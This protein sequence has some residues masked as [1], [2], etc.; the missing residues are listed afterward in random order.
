MNKKLI[1][2]LSSLLKLDEN[3]FV[4]ALNK[5]DGDE[6]VLKDYKNKYQAYTLDEIQTI[7]KNG[8]S[9]MI[10]NWEPGSK[11]IPETVYKKIAGAAIESKERN[12]AK[13]YGITD[14]SNLQD[15][16]TKI[17]ESKNGKGMDEAAKQQIEQL[18]T[19]IKKLEQEKNEAE[20]KISSKYESEFIN[21]DFETALSVLSDLDCPEE[22]K[23][24]QSTLVKNAFKGQYKLG[25]KDGKTIVLDEENKALTDRV[26]D[27]LPVSDVLKQVV[28]SSGLKFKEPDLGGRGAASSTGTINDLK[29]VDFSKALEK[30]GVKPNTSES[31]RLYTEWSAANPKAA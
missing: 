13:E 24:A 2:E 22:A 16:L 31:D 6:S 7:V 9:K 28:K 8:A 19:E 20:T 12:L 21:R 27:P 10:E 30:R 18:K 29:G 5:E 25:R 14:Y 15:L 1:V 23:Q 11:L 26:G 4:E 17:A 3:V